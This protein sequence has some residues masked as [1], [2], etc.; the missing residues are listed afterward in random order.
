MFRVDNKHDPLGTKGN[1]MKIITVVLTLILLSV[2][3]IN[4]QSKERIWK[5]G[6]LKDITTQQYEHGSVWAGSINQERIAYIVD[7]GDFTYT[8][9]HL[10]FRHDPALPITINTTVKFFI[11]KQKVILQDE[12]GKNH[13]MKLEKKAL[14][15]KD[16]N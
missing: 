5:T 3:I 16:E 15:E 11:E 7:A 13:D 2:A 4:A 10:H 12:E 6:K 9:S 8:F 14:N 1:T